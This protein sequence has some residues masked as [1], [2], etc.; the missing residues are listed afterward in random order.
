MPAAL[1]QDTS[2]EPRRSGPDRPAP[3]RRPPR[4]P[5]FNAPG[6]AIALVAII[7]GG[8]ALQSR[9]PLEAVVDGFAFSPQALAQGRWFTLVSALFLHGG[10][11]HALTNGAF[12]LAFATPVARFF[13]ERA[14]GVAAF[15]LFYLV[16]GVLSNFGYAAVHPGG[17][18]P[19]VGA[20]GAVSGLMG[21]ASRLI[22]GRGRVGPIV[23]SPV[24]G[25][26]GAWLVVNL[27]VG[28]LGGGF[29]PGTAGAG[30]AWEAHLAGFL[31]GVLLIG[32]FAL[33]AERR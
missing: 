23:S 32:P 18:E 5:V 10:W 31:A 29:L 7:V 27:L 13:G 17:A 15:F 6:A 20:S 16:C 12:A 3:D 11:G 4:E 22:S 14:G 24:L 30:V 19:L 8:Y 9:F 21:A 33:L 28:V 2:N 1:F 26:G 25:M